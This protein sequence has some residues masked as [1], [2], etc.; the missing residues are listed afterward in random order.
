MGKSKRYS[1]EIRERAVKMVLEHEEE[2]TSQWAA[3]E[4]ISEKFGCTS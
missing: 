4:S 2:Y 3:I 1:R